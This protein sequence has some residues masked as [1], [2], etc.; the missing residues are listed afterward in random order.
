[1]TAA[2][3]DVGK[4]FLDLAIDGLAGTARFPN[5]ASGQRQLVQVLATVDDPFVVVE[6][7][8]GYE[9]ALLDACASAGLVAASE[10]KRAISRSSLALA[11]GVACRGSAGISAIAPTVVPAPKISGISL[12]SLTRSAS[13]RQRRN[14]CAMPMALNSTEMA[15]PICSQVGS[16][17]MFTAHGA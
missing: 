4:A 8:G 13:T 10:L 6:A 15:T 9:D 1:M 7:T 5:D 14:R 11:S 2:G 17:M 12:S 3:V 16:G